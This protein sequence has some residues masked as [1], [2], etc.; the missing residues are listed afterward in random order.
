M[1]IRAGTGASK[2]IVNRTS[3]RKPVRQAGK[4]RDRYLAGQG[5][6]AVNADGRGG[7]PDPEHHQNGRVRV[8]GHERRLPRHV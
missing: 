6:G 4:R 5:H 1:E 7:Y 8:D 3:H 2:M